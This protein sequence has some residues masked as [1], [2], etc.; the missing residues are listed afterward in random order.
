MQSKSGEYNLPTAETI[1]M[2]DTSPN[3]DVTIAE[4]GLLYRID[5][6][7]PWYYGMFLG[8]QHYM[9]MFGSTVAVPFILAGSLCIKDNHLVLSEIIS[10]IFFVSG[11]ATLIQTTIGNRLPI[12]QGAT[13]SF[14]GPTIAI[15]SLEKFKCS[16]AT[17]IVTNSTANTTVTIEHDWKKGMLE[18]QGAIAVASI[19]QVLIGFTG[20][21]GFLLRFIGPLTVAPTVSLVG[22]ALFNAAGDFAGHQ[23]GI[24]G[25]TVLLIILFSQVLY[26]IKVFRMFPVLFAIGISWAVS[27]IITAA[28]GFDDDSLARTDRRLDVL[29]KAEW[30]RFPYP[31]QWGTP[32]VSVASVFGMLAGVLASML[33]SLGDYFACA[34]LSGAPAPPNHAVNRGIGLEGFSC[35]LAGLWG[36]GNGTTSYSENIAAI[37]ITRVGSRRVIQF[38]AVFMILLSI[39]GKFGAVFTLIPDPIVGGMFWTLFGLIVAVGLSNLQFVNLNSSR[40]LF[41]LGFAFFTGMV[42]P[43]WLGKNPTAINTDNDEVNQILNVLLQTNMAVGGVTAA[44][45]D[46]ALPG[47]LEDRGITKWRKIQSSEEDEIPQASIHV[48]DLPFIQAYL[49]KTSWAKYVPFLPYHGT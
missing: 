19:F 24:A 32:T 6:N 46:N 34:R 20:A 8:F 45:L 42:I 12:V 25:L 18:V 13:F 35:I 48:Y 49:N 44:I 4:H 41:V 2:K 47:S 11:L 38:G 21:V 3:K 37:G 36:S 39:L 10:T 17:L 14:L 22:L 28:G 7:P 30:I 5:E 29:K 16:P 33:E 40:N 27:A 43:A 9:T 23:W 15:L 31:G 1:E 26:K